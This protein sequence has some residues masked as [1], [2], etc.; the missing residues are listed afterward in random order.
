MNDLSKK[1]YKD[2]EINRELVLST[3][4]VSE[5]CHDVITRT[6][7]GDDPRGPVGLL[8]VYGYEYGAR[9][10]TTYDSEDELPKTAFPELDVLLTFAKEMGCKWLLLDCAAPA[11]ERFEVFDW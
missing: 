7:Y 9:I 6:E 8:S 11:S 4:H 10:F 3:Y 5:E 2:L 1:E